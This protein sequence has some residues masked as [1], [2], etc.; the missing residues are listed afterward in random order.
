MKLFLFR[1]G[2]TLWNVEKR[3]QGRKDSPLTDRGRRLAL[4]LAVHAKGW[5]LG[6]MITSPLGRARETA[7]ALG[8]GLGL[9]PEE[10]PRLAECSFGECEGMLWSEIKSRHSEL[11]AARS[12]DPWSFR[13]PGG[14]NYLD[15]TSRAAGLLGDLGEEPGG[16]PLALVGH[17]TINR[18]ILGLLLSLE[19]GKIVKVSHPNTVVYRVEG[20]RVHR[21]DVAYPSAGWVAGLLFKESRPST[22]KP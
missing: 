9:A 17:E 1:H 3:H 12:A 21:F 16:K 7:L 8:A 20:R 10:D 13:W 14:E 6:R 4:D 19:P 2:E 15:L 5:N 18:A 11:L 22:D